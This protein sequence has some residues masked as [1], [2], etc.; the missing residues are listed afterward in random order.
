MLLKRVYLTHKKP[1]LYAKLVANNIIGND[2]KLVIIL[3]IQLIGIPNTNWNNRLAFQLLIILSCIF[4]K[5]YNMN[6]VM[7]MG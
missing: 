5:K 6:D 2:E 1:H 7:I 4:K 3:D